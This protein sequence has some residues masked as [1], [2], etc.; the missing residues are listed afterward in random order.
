MNYGQFVKNVQ[1]KAGCT[2]KEEALRAIQAT[3]MT[4]AERLFDGEAEHLAAQ[5]PH[6]L[7]QYME[8]PEDRKNFGVD[9]FVQR[10]GQREGTDP[11]Q[12]EEHAR[13][14]IGV[15]CRAVS[16]GEIEDVLS[17][18]PKE[19]LRLFGEESQTTH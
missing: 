15:L 16:R 7:Q 19:Y 17:Q 9:E 11:A 4:L 1:E 6:E 8:Q 13:A 12:A 10:V 5:L 18:L 2:E 3:L 14:V